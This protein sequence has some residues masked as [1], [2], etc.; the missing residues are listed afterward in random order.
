MM[1]NI[2]TQTGVKNAKPAYKFA[3]KTKPASKPALGSVSAEVTFKTRQVKKKTSSQIQV[4]YDF[5]DTPARYFQHIDQANE[6]RHKANI[7]KS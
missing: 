6:S 5:D 1:E 2:K 7:A 4:F 3:K